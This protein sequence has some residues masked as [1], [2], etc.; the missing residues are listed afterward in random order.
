MTGVSMQSYSGTGHIS[1]ENTIYEIQQCQSYG[2]FSLLYMLLMLHMMI[3]SSSSNTNLFIS[4][5]SLF[6]SHPCVTICWFLISLIFLSSLPP[7]SSFYFFVSSICS[8]SLDSSTT[9]PLT[10]VWVT[11]LTIFLV[12]TSGSSAQR[13]T[14]EREMGWE[15]WKWRN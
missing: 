14:G 7:P 9:L 4:S 2:I 6:L 8:T 13:E 12:R 5:S 10:I 1:L 15:R 3:H 11:T